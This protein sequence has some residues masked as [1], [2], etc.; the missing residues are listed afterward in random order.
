MN[1]KCA[2]C[3]VDVEVPSKEIMYCVK[4]F[5]HHRSNEYY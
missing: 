3:N 2:D 5:Q 4:C 1:I